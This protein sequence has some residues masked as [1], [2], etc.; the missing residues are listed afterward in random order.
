MQKAYEKL[1]RR[2][3][4]L[5]IE[6]DEM[7]ADTV[8]YMNHPLVQTPNL[9]RLA[10]MSYVFTDHHTVAPM[11][12]PSRHALFAG[13][14][15]HVCNC[16]AGGIPL[17]PGTKYWPQILEDAGYRSAVI[18]KLHQTPYYETYGF[19]WAK[20]I[21]AHD[22]NNPYRDYL[23]QQGLPY[24]GKPTPEQAERAKRGL[25]F[26][27][28]ADHLPAEKTE[29]AFA[30]DELLAF[31]HNP[32]RQPFFMHASYRKP[33][34]G[35][36][37]PAPWDTMYD[38]ADIDVPDIP[39]GDLENKPLNLHQMRQR[40]GFDKMTRRDWAE[41][42]AHY[43][44]LVSFLDHHLG[45]VLDALEQTGLI[46]STI[47]LFTS[48]HGTMI[49]EHGLYAKFFNY[50]E[51]TKVPFLLH[52]PGQS[53][54]VRVDDTCTCLDVL[55]TVLSHCGLD[56]PGELQGRVLDPIMEG[57]ADGW[58]PNFY[59]E[60]H[61][62]MRGPNLENPHPHLFRKGLRTRQWKITYHTTLT[63]EGWIFEWELYNH[64]KDPRELV[65]LAGDPQYADVLRELKNQL[66]LYMCK[67][68]CAIDF[69]LY[70]VGA[71]K[72]G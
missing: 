57:C 32:P 51:S 8:G 70:G 31:L 58:D 41:D 18:G 45:R 52:L 24:K 50:E 60:I 56:I 67:Y 19:T 6:W 64:R 59:M 44:G 49:G 26:G 14:Y 12:A 33:H 39:E 37:P 7:R 54:S 61:G 53:Q 63:D 20:L 29:T 36:N 30:T 72:K 68:E 42:A 47:I 16:V 27:W 21:D 35:H 25:K 15:P 43:Y 66:L 40:S 28:G 34:S 11:C 46:D 5:L 23:R 2:P 1:G 9:D 69:S 3:N 71:D 13:V 55:P 62:I 17:K 22:Q 48:D 10:A 38:P 4:V 65:N